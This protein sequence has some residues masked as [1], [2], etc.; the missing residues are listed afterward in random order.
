MKRYTGSCLCE[1]ISFSIRGEIGPIQVCH[2]LQC[3]KAQGTAMATNVPV[4]T[5]DFTLEHGRDLLASFES[6]PGK[7]RVFCRQ[8]GSPIYSQLDTLPGIV[9]IRLGL[10]NERID[11]P[12]MG[13]FYAGSKANWWPICDGTPRF[14][15]GM[16]SSAWKDT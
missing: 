12:L 14:Q 16:G 7:Q 8:C 2:C 9:R 6:S 1:G 13:H 15:A 10:I 4:H 11:A 3:R 5:D